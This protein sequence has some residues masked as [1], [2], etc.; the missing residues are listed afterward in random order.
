MRIHQPPYV[1]VRLEQA[2]LVFMQGMYEEAMEVMARGSSY[3]QATGMRITR[4]RELN[5]EARFLAHSGRT[6]EA[7]A[8]V[9]EALEEAEELCVDR[10]STLRLKGDLLVQCEAQSPEVE[11]VYQQAITCARDLENKWEELQTTVRFARWLKT[12]DRRDEA[13]AMLAEIYGWFTEGLDTADL[14]DAKILIDELAH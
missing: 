8:K 1:T 11:S 3:S 9:E 6:N 5:F 7:L 2:L 13:L 4:A 12:E 14:K 10:P